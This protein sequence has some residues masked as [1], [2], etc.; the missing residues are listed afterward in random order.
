MDDQRCGFETSSHLLLHLW[1]QIRLL[2]VSSDIEHSSW[3]FSGVIGYLLAAMV[4]VLPLC[5]ERRTA[6][7]IRDPG[8]LRADVVE[9]QISCFIQYLICC[10]L[11]VLVTGSLYLVG[12]M[13][14]LLGKAP[15]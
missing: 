4:C 7:N 1:S 2:S 14:R 15:S 8:G 6:I 3:L 13:L 11:Q 9:V 10:H 12:D 5:T